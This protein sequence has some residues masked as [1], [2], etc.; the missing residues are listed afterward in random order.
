[1]SSC[2]NRHVVRALVIAG[3]IGSCTR[4]KFIG[5]AAACGG[6][7]SDAADDLPRGLFG[8]E[9]LPGDAYEVITLGEGGLDVVPKKTAPTP[10]DAAPAVKDAA[11]AKKKKKKAKKAK[12]TQASTEEAEAVEKA[13]AEGAA[14]PAD[15]SEVLTSP[16]GTLSL[17]SLL[18]QAIQKVSTITCVVCLWCYCATRVV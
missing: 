11:K 9:E 16:W 12:A 4:T 14:E 15:L 17:H 8:L 2:Y 10:V 13:E 6:Q 7:V 18:L 5:I 3:T 1:M